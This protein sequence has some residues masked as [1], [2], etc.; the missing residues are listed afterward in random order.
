MANV[1]IL[2]I[3]IYK[4][5]EFKQKISTKF[6]V[7]EPTASTSLL[8][9]LRIHILHHKEK[10]ETF[11]SGNLRNIFEYKIFADLLNLFNLLKKLPKIKFSLNPRCCRA[12]K[13]FSGRQNKS[14]DSNDSLYSKDK[15]KKSPTHYINVWKLLLYFENQY[16]KPIANIKEEFK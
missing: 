15:L 3:L 8:I 11:V 5:L 13:T 6:D 4:I 9:F 2:C 16:L 1:R 10:S 7:Y 14:K 12:H